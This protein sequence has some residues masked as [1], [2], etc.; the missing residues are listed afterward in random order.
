MK[1]V[2]QIDILKYVN[3]LK[4]MKFVNQI[5]IYAIQSFRPCYPNINFVEYFILFHKLDTT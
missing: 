2:N 5:Y 3:Q 1:N 4:I